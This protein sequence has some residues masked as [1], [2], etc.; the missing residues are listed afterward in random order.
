[1]TT[2]DRTALPHRS[3]MSSLRKTALIAGALYLVTFVTSIPTLILYGPVHGAGYILGSGPD[4]GVLW[5]GI[6][7]VLLALSGA[8]T[9]IALY[10]VVRRQNESL[11]LGFVASRV[12]EA[13][14]ILV[15]VMSLLTVVTLR[16]N[17]SGAVGTDTASLATGGAVLVAFHDWTFVLAQSLMPAVNALLL[18]TLMYR[19]GLVPR[20]IPLLGLVGAPLLLGSVTATIFGL[21]EQSSGVAVIA[22][23][24][25][26][27]WELSLGIWLVV[28]GFRASPER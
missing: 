13:A 5:G 4:T 10:P 27:L 28:K 24:P 15:G 19:S 26:A 9:A 21:Y 8:G 18:G 14:G 3:P 20:I 16:Q 11:A 17:L 1:M 12:L 6:L 2:V 25:V 7:E 22:A 23:L